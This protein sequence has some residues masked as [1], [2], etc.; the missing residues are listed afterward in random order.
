M[1]ARAT[2]FL[3]GPYTKQCL[4]PSTRSRDASVL[5][6]F[7]RGAAGR[8][9]KRSARTIPADTHAI[10]PCERWAATDLRHGTNAR[11]GPSQAAGQAPS[12]RRREG[13]GRADLRSA[14]ART[15]SLV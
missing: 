1:G 2:A 6:S 10:L 8:K 3:R 4:L 14:D 11:R 15:L 5:H 9:P 12:D 7:P 13:G